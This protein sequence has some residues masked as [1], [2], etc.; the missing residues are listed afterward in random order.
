MELSK[1]KTIVRLVPAELIETQ[2]TPKSF[3]KYEIKSDSKDGSYELR[4]EGK[5]SK[6]INKKSF[7][8]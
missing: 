8:S 7:K 4:L 5:F 6:K 2:F 1:V 3:T